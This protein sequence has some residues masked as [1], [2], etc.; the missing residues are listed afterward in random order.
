MSATQDSAGQ[1]PLRVDLIVAAA[2]QDRAV[3]D[4]RLDADGVGDQSFRPAGEI[5]HATKWRRT[6]RFWIEHHDIRGATAAQQPA[7]RDPHQLR[8][9]LRQ[10]MH[11]GFE[12]HRALVS[13]PMA[14][15]VCRVAGVAELARV[16]ARVGQRHDGVGVGDELL[17]LALVV[18]EEG[19][20]EAR[21]ELG[22]QGHVED[23][24]DRVR[25][26]GLRDCGDACSSSDGSGG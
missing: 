13:H 8:R 19:D 11:G 21:R 9:A 6:D 5:L 15:Q 10:G 18:V 26:P 22:L 3:D 14:Q 24:V 25:T 2:A 17:Y 16:R 1:V 12:A 23:Q 7:V 4:H 20:A